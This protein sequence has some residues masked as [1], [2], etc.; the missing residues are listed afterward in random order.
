MKVKL[1]LEDGQIFE[2]SRMGAVKDVICELVF[3]T[4]VTGY[5]E[6]MTDPSYAGQGVIMSS[7]IIGN[8]GVFEEDFESQRPRLSAFIVRYITELKNDPRNAC[9]L[10]E[11]LK[12]HDIPGITDID[13]RLLT[14]TI[15]EK[16]TM[17]GMITGDENPNLNNCLNLI[18]EYKCPS[19]VPEVSTSKICKAKDMI[20]NSKDRNLSFVRNNKLRNDTY[21]K[22]FKVALIDYGAKANIGRLLEK[23]G[24]DVTYFPWNSTAEEIVKFAP[25]GIMLSNGPGDPKECNE[26]IE[27]IKELYHSDIPIFGICLGHQ[28]MALAAGFDT[29]KLRYGHRGI[30]HPVRNEITE[31]C[32]ITSQN[33]S[34]S[35]IPESIN[36]N[37]AKISY[38]NIN[39]S[40]IE[41]LE[42]CNKDIFTVQFHPEGAPGPMDTVFLFEKFIKI[43][44][45]RR[46]FKYS[47][48]PADMSG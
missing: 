3:N 9:D 10:D 25:E 47:V 33:H 16:G 21:G 31:K 26:S 34:Y 22:N 1:I 5:V 28:L 37:L 29:F 36:E 13:T 24:C 44:D 14:L 8:Y 38:I 45:G 12:K 20:E 27:A 15:R 7:P 39:D 19:K 43:M 42:Y 23:Y 11:F 40:S 41:G 18:R 48:Y 30:N 17:K 2:G 46:P 6:L 4:A 32:Y 35:V